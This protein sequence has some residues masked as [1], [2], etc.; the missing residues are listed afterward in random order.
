MELPEL[1]SVS[2]EEPFNLTWQTSVR[3]VLSNSVVS[4]SDTTSNDLLSHT[5]TT[6]KCTPCSKIAI[7][8]LNLSKK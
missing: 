7:P 3:E 1:P 8:K 4:T 2:R 5:S 6:R